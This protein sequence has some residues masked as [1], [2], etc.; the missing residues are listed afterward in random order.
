V[1]RE[2]RKVARGAHS[3]TWTPG[4]AGRYVLTLEAVDQRKNTTSPS[5][6]ITVR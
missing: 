1:F 2:R 4:A 3:F 5:F 6:K